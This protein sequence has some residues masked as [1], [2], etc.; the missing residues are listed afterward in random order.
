MT[1]MGA[2]TLAILAGLAIGLVVN[3]YVRRGDTSRQQLVRRTQFANAFALIFLAGI[4]GAKVVF[5]STSDTFTTVLAVVTG[6]LGVFF[7]VQALR[8][9]AVQ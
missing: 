8:R 2:L 6:I 9:K 5:S 1:P 3:R 4:N 7:L